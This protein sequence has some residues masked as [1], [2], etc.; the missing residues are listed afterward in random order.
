MLR[1][2]KLFSA[3]MAA[4]LLAT[5]AVGA[6]TPTPTSMPTALPE[7]AAPVTWQSHDAHTAT[8]AYPSPQCEPCEL[9]SACCDCLCGPPGRVW[10]SGEW[11]YWAAAGQP[12]PALVTASPPGTPRNLA[13][14]AGG[15]GTTTLLGGSSRLNNDFRNGYRLRAGMWLDDCQ[16]HGIEGEFF[17]LGRSRE[18]GTFGGDPTQI[19]SRPFVNALTGRPDAELVSFPGVLSGTVNVDATSEVIGGGF[20]GIH[21]ICCDP[22]GRFDLIA[23]FR[24]LNL[25]DTLNITENLSAQARS[26]VVPGTGIVVRDQFTTDN[27][28]YGGVI[29]ANYE[30]RFSSFFVGV[31]ASVALGLSHQEVGIDGSTTFTPPGMAPVTLPG[32]LLAQPSNIGRY[33][34]DEF[35]VIPEVGVRVGSQL[36]ERL[37][38]FV[39]Y[40][41]IYWSNVARAGDQIDPVVNPNQLPP[42]TLPIAG[43][44]RPAPRTNVT[45]FW[46]Q[47]VSAGAEF[48]F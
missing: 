26:G 46:L 1:I 44:A 37:R 12:V 32:G 31:R 13:G 33:T 48:R 7:M 35:A 34:N 11:L 29:G 10:V 4:G 25:R 14:V 23:G 17:F 47:G 42:S 6:D 43:P 22:C 20:N 28:F 15:P 30:R 19:V 18:G 5:T 2:S 9:S 3:G 24:Y 38:G 8:A 36:T 27:D 21:N 45:D 39:G 16:T 40:N 41:W